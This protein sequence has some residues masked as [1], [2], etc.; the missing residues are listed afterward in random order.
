MLQR[1]IAYKGLTI[2]L[3]RGIS[4]YRCKS[5]IKLHIYYK[6]KIR[7]GYKI[8]I[9]KDFNCRSGGTYKIRVRILEYLI[10]E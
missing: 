8:L 3:H 6:V 9:C 2:Y 10:F 4:D 1:S 7:D 5:V